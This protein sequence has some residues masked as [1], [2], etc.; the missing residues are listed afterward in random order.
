MCRV[1]VHVCL[2]LMRCMLCSAACSSVQSEV[3][4]IFKRFRTTI[5]FRPASREE[6]HNALLAASAADARM[7]RWHCSRHHTCQRQPCVSQWLHS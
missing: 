3:N 7:P 2:A 1:T 6:R 5:L 4:G